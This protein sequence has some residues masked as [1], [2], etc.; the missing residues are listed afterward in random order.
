MIT[1][2][3][4]PGREAV[5]R[6]PIRESPGQEVHV[7]SV[8]DTGFTDFLTLPV[9]LVADLAL[10]FAGARPM[11]L[12]DGRVVDMDAFE[13]TVVWDGREREVM[14]LAAEGGV[15]VGMAMLSGYRLTLD[16]EDSGA[17]LIEG[18]R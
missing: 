15:L 13:G 3:V 8:I 16:V 17:V 9:H 1:G 5:I 7:E 12:A 6:L 4:T 14:L 18:L 10:P 11:Q 2:F